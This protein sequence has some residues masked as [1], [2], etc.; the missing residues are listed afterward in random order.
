VKLISINSGDVYIEKDGARSKLPCDTV[1]LAMGLKSENALVKELDGK[2]PVY[3]VGDCRQPGKILDA[4]EGA[5]K[6]VLSL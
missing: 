5:R 4:I 6:I 2:I 3:A 1:V